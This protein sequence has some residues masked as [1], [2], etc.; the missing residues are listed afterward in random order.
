MT[1]RDTRQFLFELPQDMTL[2]E[3]RQF[4]FRVEAQDADLKPREL[5]RLV[6]AQLEARGDGNHE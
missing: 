1:V 4:M 3:L 6:N 2:R 5:A